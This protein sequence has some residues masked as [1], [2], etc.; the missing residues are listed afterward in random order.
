[1]MQAKELKEWLSGIED[2]RLVFI[3]EGGLT[4]RV[5]G[6]ISYIEVG[7]GPII[8]ECMLCKKNGIYKCAPPPGGE[9]CKGFAS[10]VE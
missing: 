8:D 9:H 7:G 4:L 3:D 10:K 5:L 2:D 6:Q 1:M